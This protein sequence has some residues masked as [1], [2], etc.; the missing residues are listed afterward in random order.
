MENEWNKVT[1]CKTKGWSICC[2]IWGTSQR[3]K[4]D[5]KM[6]IDKE[7][8]ILCK[9]GNLRKNIVDYSTFLTKNR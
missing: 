5:R 1:T 2:Q 7:K 4:K 6:M 9:N 8:T 3:K